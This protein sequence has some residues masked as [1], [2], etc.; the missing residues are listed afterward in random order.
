MFAFNTTNN[1]GQKMTFSFWLKTNLFQFGITQ[2]ELGK[3]LGLHESTISKWCIGERYPTIKHLLMLAELI[4]ERVDIRGWEAE[5]NALI[6]ELVEMIA[7][8]D[9]RVSCAV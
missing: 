1:N 5:K 4:A 3:N 9:A 6:V 2:R 7:K 8:E